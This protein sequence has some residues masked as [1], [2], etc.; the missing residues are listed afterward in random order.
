MLNLLIVGCIWA[1]QMAAQQPA[2]DEAIAVWL[3][4][5]EPVDCSLFEEG[6]PLPS[7]FGVVD[8]KEPSAMLV[9]LSN[10]RSAEGEDE[11]TVLC[12]E[13]R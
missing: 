5:Q 3:Q 9:I 8:V 1:T 2:A 11:V 6:M 12:A 7:H 13:M 4:T 10:P